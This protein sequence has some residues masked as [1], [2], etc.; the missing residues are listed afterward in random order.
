MIIEIEL[1]EEDVAQLDAR[2]RSLGLQ[3]TG[4]NRRAHRRGEVVRR[5]L[6]LWRV[7]SPPVPARAHRSDADERWVAP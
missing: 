5:A 7:S 2:A 3:A 6:A 4:E 1:S